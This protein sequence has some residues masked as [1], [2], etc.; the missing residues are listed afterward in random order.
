MAVRIDFYAVTG[1][2]KL[3]G[4]E[5]HDF[6]AAGTDGSPLRPTGFVSA[7]DDDEQLL[8]A[9]FSDVADRS[10]LDAVTEGSGV[11][12]AGDVASTAAVLASASSEVLDHVAPGGAQHDLAQHWVTAAA[13]AALAALSSDAPLAW[14]T[15]YDTAGSPDDGPLEFPTAWST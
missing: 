15:R 11:I 10:D 2:V 5:D 12:R 3:G 4:A 8:F 1:P 9:L 14:H 13:R 7:S 6:D